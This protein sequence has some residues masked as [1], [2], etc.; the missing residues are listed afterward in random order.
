MHGS[1]DSALA[2]A[3]SIADGNNLKRLSKGFPEYAE[4][5]NSFHHDEGWWFNVLD[6]V[7]GENYQVVERKPSGAIV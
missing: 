4:A 1:F 7:D 6:T 5:M 3:L 2:E